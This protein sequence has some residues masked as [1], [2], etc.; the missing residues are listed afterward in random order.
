MW[1]LEPASKHNA[2]IPMLL[3]LKIASMMKMMRLLASTLAFVG[4]SA[5][6]SSAQSLIP[7][8][9]EAIKRAVVFLY[10]ADPTGQ[11]DTTKELAT[12]FLIQIPTQN[13]PNKS[14]FALVTARHV[15]DPIWACTSSQN[16]ATIY[17]RLNRKTYDPVHD[18]SGVEFVKVPLVA[19]NK[20]I[21]SKHR[22]DSVDAVLIPIDSAKFFANDVAAIRVADFPTPEE[23][24][25][26]GIG[27][28]IVSAGLVPGLSGKKRNYPFFKF[29]KVSNIPDELGIMPCGNQ[30]K[31]VNYW[32]IAAT[33]IGGNSGSPIF[34]LPPGNAVMSFGNRRPFLLGLQ[35]MSVVAGEIAGMTPASLIFEIIESLKLPD[36]NLDR[37]PIKNPPAGSKEN[38]H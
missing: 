2:Y 25:A 5:W 20:I 30:V 33:M 8:N 11:P 3:W 38:P 9:T 17:A 37:S 19:S 35:S 23:L 4:L 15:V 13:D 36:A 1:W 22:S 14:Y 21:W 10:A 16:P 32:Y 24:R 26:V 12:G 31:P 18:A 28:D 6:W 7:I 27:E 34:L 29:G